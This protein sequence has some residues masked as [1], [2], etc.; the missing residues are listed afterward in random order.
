MTVIDLIADGTAGND[1][2]IQVATGG[3]LL[4]TNVATFVATKSS[5]ND[6]LAKIVTTASNATDTNVDLTLVT[7]SSGF[8]IDDKATDAS[9]FATLTGTQH[10]DVFELGAGTKIVQGAGGNDTINLK[11]A[12]SKFNALTVTSLSPSDESTINIASVGSNNSITL[13]TTQSSGI[14]NLNATVATTVTATVVDLAGNGGEI[15]ASGSKVQVT[16]QGAM[17]ND[18]FISGQGADQMTGDLGNDTFVINQGQLVTVT[19]LGGATGK[20]SDV[21]IVNS[22]G[23]VKATSVVEFKATTETVNHGSAV[24]ESNASGSSIDLSLASKGNG[25]NITGGNGIDTITTSINNDTVDGGAGD[26][27]ITSSGGLVNVTGGLGNDTINVFSGTTTLNDLGG[28]TGTEDVV[29]VSLGATLNATSKGFTATAATSNAG[30]S[31]I[32]T[33][34]S[35]TIDLF[36]A[37]GSSGFT[38]DSTDSTAANTLTLI[39]TKL[40]DTFNLGIGTN[41]VT[42]TGGADT[43][44]ANA[45]GINNITVD[46]TSSLIMKATAGVNTITVTGIGNSVDNSASNV[47][48]KITGGTGADTLISDTANDTLDG[49][50]GNDTFQITAGGLVTVEKLGGIVPGGESDVLIVT[51][52]AA[53]KAVDVVK[54]V[55]NGMSINNGTAE[56][57]ADVGG[58]EINLSGIAAGH[59]FTLTGGLGDDTITSSQRG[60]TITGGAGNDTFNITTG[61][62]V[63]LHDLGATT[64]KDVLV[65]SNGAHLYADNVIKFVATTDT[66]NAGS[67]TIDLAETGGSIDLSALDKTTTLV[68]GFTI[69]GGGSKDVIKGSGASDTITGGD[70][71]DE[72]TLMALALRASPGTSNKLIINDI[73]DGSDSGIAGG[74][75]IGFD[76]VKGFVT[77]IDDIQLSS[78]VFSPYGD[79]KGDAIRIIPGTQ[80]ID[81]LVDI[82]L[83]DFESVD[84][85]LSFFRDVEDQATFAFSTNKTNVIAINDVIG[86]STAVYAVTDVVKEMAAF[87]NFVLLGIHAPF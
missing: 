5:S 24:I 28:T 9:K 36:L 20:E 6:G 39:G 71:G 44:I 8:T 62:Q 48:V 68:N 78:S 56:I 16:F 1:D 32:K 7:G 50:A 37:T 79:G 86:N 33:S 49:G 57:V 60:D 74:K 80:A 30:N 69:N 55:A 18:T 42:T 58:G 25:F 22:N 83:A 31:T 77:G 87:F 53:V 3:D 70:G 21:L 27:V 4:A 63:T 66:K 81:P 35:A 76:V 41:N 59:G 40:A 12:N 38:L 2:V 84:R 51:A 29:L 73:N 13:N 72:I 46:G 61:A 67:V 17:G 43:V 45:A 52:N 19:D 54:F 47:A 85:V 10:A 64:G 34:G 11:V 26:D 23:V 75:F 15:N 82:T 14:L 65:V